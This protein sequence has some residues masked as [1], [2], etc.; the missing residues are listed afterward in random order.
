MEGALISPYRGA[1]VATTPVSC[2][3]VKE[4]KEPTHAR[5]VDTVINSAKYADSLRRRRS[6]RVLFRNIHVHGLGTEVRSGA[7]ESCALGC[8]C[9]RSFEVNIGYHHTRCS[10]PGKG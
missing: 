4:E 1:T 6:H 10:L 5:A 9:L 2:V 8:H 3:V 7:S